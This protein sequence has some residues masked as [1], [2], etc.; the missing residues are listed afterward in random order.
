MG[1]I[2]STPVTAQHLQREQSTH[3]QAGL[4]EVQGWRDDHEDAHVME[5]AWGGDN[6]QRGLF[7]IFDG[8][9]GTSSADFGSVYLPL[10]MS[11]KKALTDEEIVQYFIEC[12]EAYRASPD[13]KAGAAV[14]M[15][16]TEKL[17]NS[18]KYKVRFANAGDS[19]AILVSMNKPIPTEMASLSLVEDL[20]RKPDSDLSEHPEHLYSS[21]GLHFVSDDFDCGVTLSTVD[22]KPN[23][24]SER[25][26]IEAAG[27]FVS[28]DN[29][30]RLQG[31]LALSRMIGDFNYKQNPALGPGEQMGSCIPEIFT[32]EANEGD[33]VILACDGIFDVLSNNELAR[34]V[35]LR[36][37][38]QLDAGA[39]EPDLAKIASDIVSLCLTRLDSKDNMSL[40]IVVLKG[41]SHPLPPKMD[42]ELLAGDFTRIHEQSD[43][44]GGNSNDKRMRKAYEDFFVKVGYFK[45][46]NHCNVCH[47]YFKQMSSCPCKKAIYCDQNCQKHDWKVHRKV[48]PSVKG[49]KAVSPKAAAA[50]AAAVTAHPTK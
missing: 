42:D 26:R 33:L 9:G 6:T 8:H 32:A 12:D 18:N 34:Q 35:R 3:L 16:T 22:H 37:K 11:T 45:H 38:H 5:T 47:R 31:M 4:A 40:C 21:E 43:I 27:G 41:A 48:C 15:V 13:N 28:N 1:S 49:S 19:R 20:H 24:P 17:A 29:P 25:T 44:P 30:A 39:P 14:C 23:H 2:L 46:P 10:K 7:V 50:A 36:I